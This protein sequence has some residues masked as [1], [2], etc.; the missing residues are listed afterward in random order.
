V[1]GSGRWRRRLLVG[2][3]L[4][5]LAPVAWVAWEA[6]RWPDVG[7][8]AR[9]NPRS[10]AFIDAYRQ[11]QRAAGRDD[12]VAWQWTPYG[13]IAPSLKRAVLVAEDINFFT[14]NGFELTELRSALEQAWEE[15]GTPRGAS[16]IT[17][18]LAKNLW[19]SPSRNPLRKV[20]EAVLTWQLERA[21][22]K[23]RILELYLNVVELGPGV[24]GCGA[25]SRRYFEK[26]PA[27][28]TEREAALL[29]ASLPSP[30]RWHP[31]VPSRAYA[32]YVDTIRRRME[33]ADF[34]WRQ[35]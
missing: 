28:L 32:R 16:T 27:D 12:R 15:L 14:H 26:P 23:R 7:A 3:V 29:A 20:K 22:T 33:K 17:Q 13:E 18:Q 5:L 31:G 24:Y 21:L 19:L 25:A 2:L 35:I 9:R 4:L 10:T 34:L 30:S 8:L 6:S 1:K 11:R